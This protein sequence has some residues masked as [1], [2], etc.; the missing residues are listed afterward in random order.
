MRGILKALVA[1]ELQLRSDSLFLFLHRQPDRIQHK[2]DRLSGRCLVS[3]NAVVIQ[4]P[5]YGQIQYT[6]LRMDVGDVR[7]PFCIRPVCP[8]LSVQ[9][10]LVL[11]YLLSKVNPLFFIVAEIDSLI[12]S[13]SNLPYIISSLLKLYQSWAL[14]KAF[15]PCCMSN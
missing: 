3:Y 5:D 2:I 9:Q 1:V 11:M 13:A 7:D 12:L 4:I 10:I 15:R 6:L 8:E 14:H